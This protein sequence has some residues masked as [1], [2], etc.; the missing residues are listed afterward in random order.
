MSTS[1]AEKQQKQYA[2]KEQWEKDIDNFDRSQRRREKRWRKH[3]VRI[4][5]SL[6]S[7]LTDNR[8]RLSLDKLND[9]EPGASF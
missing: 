3:V 8:G 5:A 9:L 2:E 6:M 7:Q 1:V 4:D